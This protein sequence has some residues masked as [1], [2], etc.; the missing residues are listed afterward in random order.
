MSY[1]TET[2]ITLHGWIATD[3][4]LSV[5][6]NGSARAA[7]RLAVPERRFDRATAAWATAATSYYSVVC[8]RR[9]AEH[10]ASSLCRGD[11]ALVVG[12]LRVVEW[13]K[14]GRQGTAVEVEAVSLGHD[15]RFGV[16]DYRPAPR[17]P[18]EALA[19]AS[20]SASAGSM[21][22]ASELQERAGQQTIALPMA[23]SGALS[24][25]ATDSGHCDPASP[26]D[27]TAAAA[28]LIAT[29]IAT[30][31][32]RP[33]AMPA[34]AIAA[35]AAAAEPVTAVAEAPLASSSSEAPDTEAKGPGA[36]RHG[37]ARPRSRPHDQRRAQERGG[38]STGSR[39]GPDRAL[40]PSKL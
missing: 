38:P 25:T 12:R 39:P 23:A 17:E 31:H 8:W 1:S 11:P 26:S 32:S 19:R 40:A 34:P 28:A 18:K 5:C 3:P 27:P 16:S 13:A 6:A 36:A 7:F 33:A 14:E 30:A 24:S 10:A 37:A 29:T 9:L 4:K 22:S 21:A 2:Q 15:L 20:D 35:A